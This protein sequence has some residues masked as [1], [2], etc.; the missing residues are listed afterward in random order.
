MTCCLCH[1]LAA[2]SSASGANSLQ[3]ENALWLILLWRKTV[4]KQINLLVDGVLCW[5]N[6]C[7]DSWSDVPEYLAVEPHMFISHVFATE[8]PK[9]F[10][11]PKQVEVWRRWP[12]LISN[13]QALIFELLDADSNELRNRYLDRLVAWF[14][15]FGVRKLLFCSEIRCFSDYISVFVL[16]KILRTLS[17]VGVSR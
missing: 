3:L 7:G 13:H 5:R 12:R 14:W 2:F 8:P 9:I 11:T 4:S 17:C 16:W 10:A 6:R 15:R 1:V